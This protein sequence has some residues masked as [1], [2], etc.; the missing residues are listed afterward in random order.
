MRVLQRVGFFLLL[1]HKDSASRYWEIDALRGMGY[2]RANVFVGPWLVFARVTAN[3]F[4]LLVGGSLALSHAR[5]NPQASG[6][7]LYKNY[8]ARGLKLV[9]WG[10]TV[11][12]A[13]WIYMGKAVIIFGI[14]HLIGTAIILAYPFLSLR[15][16]NL[17]IGTAIIALGMYLNNLPVTHPWLL[18]LGL[19][20]PML[21]QADYFPLLPWFGIVLLGIFV[22]QL[23]Y[24]GGTRRFNL[25]SLGGWSGMKELVWL[26]RHSL[27]I[28]LI[29]QPFLFAILNLI[30][31]VSLGVGRG[32]AM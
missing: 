25:P 5:V 7:S 31:V 28:Y 13:T 23:L 3:L 15:W 16:A 21:Y 8:G 12:L 29:H 24:P 18:W 1:H 27:I 22:G 32:G 19:R 10:I 11:T 9:G 4:I 26:G 14:L 2:Y 30:N 20:P 6:W 17:A